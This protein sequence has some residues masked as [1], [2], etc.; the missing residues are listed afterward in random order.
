MVMCAIRV[1]PS[2]SLTERFLQECG[3]GMNF[4]EPNI[5]LKDNDL[6]TKVRD[7]AFTD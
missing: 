1:L 6:M 3:D 4:H 7:M 2:P 5:V